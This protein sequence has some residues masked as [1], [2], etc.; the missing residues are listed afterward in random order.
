MLMLAHILGLALALIV[1]QYT[2]GGEIFTAEYTC[3]D[4][5]ISLEG[6]KKDQQHPVCIHFP[7]EPLMNW[8]EAY[9][10]C[11]SHYAR[12]V[13]PIDRYDTEALRKFLWNDKK[14]GDKLSMWAGYKRR[15]FASAY[16]KDVWEELVLEPSYYRDIYDQSIVMPES[17]WRPGQPNNNE[18]NK[19]KQAL[20][21]EHCTARKKLKHG[22][23]TEDENNPE[24]GERYFYGLDDYPCYNEHL[25]LCER[26]APD[27]NE[28][29]EE[30]KKRK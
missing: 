18:L 8:Y 20:G 24:E 25:T 1:P 10:Y 26:A 5:W 30:Y 2:L 17:A 7:E 3:D 15:D 13:Q 27:Q 6:Y 29:N 12:I 22:P 14:Q 19:A 9:E 23:T 28:V 16:P 4:G 11:S 21:Q